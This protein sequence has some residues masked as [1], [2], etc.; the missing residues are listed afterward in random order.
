MTREEFINFLK[1]HEIPFSEDTN[2]GM[3]MV[4]VY[5]KVEYEIKQ[6]HPRR[7]K[8]LYVPYLR[9]SNFNGEWYTREDGWCSYMPEEVVIEKCLELGEARE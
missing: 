9:V 8:N 1:D 6:K 7:F 3:D 5:S 4:Y 2:N